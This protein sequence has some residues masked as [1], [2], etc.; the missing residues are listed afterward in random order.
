MTDRLV[1]AFADIARG[2]RAILGA[3][4][5]ERYTAHV[6]V[7]HPECEPVSRAQF[8]RERMESR[9]SKPGSRCC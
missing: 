1:S 6:R 4:D 9:Y 2:L 8:E 7:A 3:P 5:Y